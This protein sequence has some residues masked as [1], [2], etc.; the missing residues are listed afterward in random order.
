MNYPRALKRNLEYN[1]HKAFADDQVTE[2]AKALRLF[3]ISTSRILGGTC[4]FEPKW[5]HFFFFH[6][7]KCFL[8]QCTGH[9]WP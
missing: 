9:G 3:S 7:I 2:P 1:N 5:C 8:L 6:E 4:E